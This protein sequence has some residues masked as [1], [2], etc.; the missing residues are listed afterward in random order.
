MP[1][2]EPP[3]PPLPYLY[4]IGAGTHPSANP[5]YDQLSF[6]FQGGFPSYDIE[7]VPQL[8]A[9]GSGAR[10]PLPGTDAILRVVFRQAQAHLE[11]GGSSIISAPPAAIGH[12]AISRYAPAGDI[13][14]FVTYGIGIGR[15]AG[16]HPQTRVRVYEVERIALGKHLYVVAIQVDATPW[17]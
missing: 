1:I 14:G 4:S 3:A 10:I 16:T 15:T 7:Y 2:A 9:E 8:V 17:R 5:P 11:N 12:S 6:R 13:E